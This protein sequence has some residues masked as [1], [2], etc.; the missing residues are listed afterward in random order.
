MHLLDNVDVSLTK[1]VLV[2]VFSV[3]HSAKFNTSLQAS[4]DVSLYKRA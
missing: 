3:T 2:N 1:H 4:K